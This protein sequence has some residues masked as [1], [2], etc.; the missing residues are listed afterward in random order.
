MSGKGENVGNFVLVTVF[1]VQ[2][3][4]ALVPANKKGDRQRCHL[5][6]EK[7]TGN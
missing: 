4:D 5:P 6:R 2:V 3:A 1:P 7:P